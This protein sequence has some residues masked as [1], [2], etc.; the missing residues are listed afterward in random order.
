MKAISNEELEKFIAILREEPVTS[1]GADPSRS[2]R[3]VPN[4]SKQPQGQPNV[5]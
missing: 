2:Q 4:E 3:S 1:S 5:G